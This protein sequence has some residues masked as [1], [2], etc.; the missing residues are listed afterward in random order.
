MARKKTEEKIEENIIDVEYSDVMKKSYIDY[1]MSVIAGRALADVRD[2]FKPVQRRILHAMNELPVPSDKPHRK[3]ARIVGDTMGKYHPHGDSSIYGAQVVMAQDFKMG[4]KL[5]DGQGN[6]GSIEGDGAAA[7]RYTEARLESFTEDTILENLKYNTVEFIPNYDETEKEPVVLPAIVPNIL[8]NGSEGIAVG[9]KASLPPHNLDEVID[10][11][12]KVLDKPEVETKELLKVL[13]GPDFPTGGIISNQSDL[14]EMYETGK[15]KIRV[16]A[17]IVEEKGKNQK[18]NLV[19]TEIPYTMIGAGI[20][21]LPKSIIDLVESKTLPDI[22]DVSNESSKEGIRIVV[23]LKAGADVEYNKNMLYKKTGLE[24]TYGVQNLVICD[25]RPETLG[26][27]RILEEFIDFQYEIYGIKFSN[28]LKKA[29]KKR[30][31]DEGLIKAID[32]IDT[33]IE[34]LRGSKDK[35]QTKDC[36]INGNTSGI[37]FKTKQAEKQAKGLKFTEAQTDAILAMRLERLIG[38]E[39]EALQKDYNKLMEEINFYNLVLSSDEE[40]KKEI[41]KQLKDIKKKYHQERRT[42]IIDLDPIVIEER[43]EEETEVILLMDKFGYVHTIDVNTYEKNKETADNDNKYVIKTTNKSKLLV[44]TDNGKMHSIKL[45]DIPHGK[46]KD[47]GQALDNISNYSLKEEVMVGATTIRS[48]ETGR[49]F[50]F[51]TS[52][53]LTKRVDI[54]EFDVSRKTID[55]TKLKAGAKVLSVF[56]Y[57]DDAQIMFVTNEGYHLRFRQN[58]IPVKKKL[59]AGVTGISLIKNDYVSMVYP[60]LNGQIEATENDKVVNIEQVRTANR[61]G[62]G[63]KLN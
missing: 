30:E 24:D 6:F 63:K 61:S 36:L 44:F 43:E 58:T 39:L 57:I 4:R 31:I 32:V 29:E 41:K 46:L 35:K 10:A 15:G 7:M 56:E 38:L 2:G 40:M 13:K 54:S 25:G 18:T 19:I 33:I 23:E 3:S 22:T 59:A 16:R 45:Q 21:K 55:A 12:I 27:K 9:M 42:E 49:E 8:I 26:L 5:I 17:K 50:I 62:R 48:G 52:D 14:L 37:K 1:A 28:L 34:V 47:K 60:V 51:A 11:T 20:C 53:G